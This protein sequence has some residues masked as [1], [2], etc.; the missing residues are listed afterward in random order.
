MRA[1]ITRTPYFVTLFFSPFPVAIAPST[2]VRITFSAVSK[3]H[4]ILR[5]ARKI[6]SLHFF[7]WLKIR[8][9]RSRSILC[10]VA[11]LYDCRGEERGRGSSYRLFLWSE[12]VPII[13]SKFSYIDPGAVSLLFCWTPNI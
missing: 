1:C 7:V 5:L 10:L 2:R 11:E 3:S 8:T 4:S 12:R 6:I 13:Y 9:E